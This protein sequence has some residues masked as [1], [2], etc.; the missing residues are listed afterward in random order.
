LRTIL[1][2]LVF[3]GMAAAAEQKQAQWLEARVVSQERV[4]N[5][6]VA[7]GSGMSIGAGASAD[8]MVVPIIDSYV[9]IETNEAQF[10]L[11]ENRRKIFE[12]RI[13]PLVAPVNGTIKYTRAGDQFTLL[14][15][16]GQ[17]HKFRLAGMT[18]LHSVSASPGMP[19]RVQSS[20]IEDRLMEPEFG[21]Q[22]YRAGTPSWQATKEVN[23]AMVALRT[24]H[25][26]LDQMTPFMRIVMESIRPNWAQRIGVDEYLESLYAVA[27]YAG[28]ATTAREIL[29]Q[30]E[31]AGTPQK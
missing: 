17:E 3:V 27:K 11:V 7:G 9:T 20:R 22:Q 2:A 10:R 6:A 14:D 28:F 19:S 18:E 12:K 1:S 26:D 15:T 16:Q 31:R 21:Y 24:A 13:A 30:R 29:A 23:D 25:P 5:G 4:Q 8:V